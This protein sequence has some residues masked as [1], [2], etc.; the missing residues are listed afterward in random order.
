MGW[1]RVGWKSAKVKNAEFSFCTFWGSSVSFFDVLKV[2]FCIFCI[3]VIFWHIFDKN[4]FLTHKNCKKR[5]I[6][7][8]CRKC[9][10]SD[11]TK[12][13][14]NWRK[15][16]FFVIFCIFSRFCVF[17]YFCTFYTCVQK[18]VQKFN[19]HSGI[20]SAVVKFRNFVHV[21]LCIFNKK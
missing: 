9:Y 16:T 13:T 1:G 10:H 19:R 21:F 7:V 17:S 11:M 18:S 2:H 15:I 8:F 3:F 12:N 20:V 14:K 5:G 4:T 6:L